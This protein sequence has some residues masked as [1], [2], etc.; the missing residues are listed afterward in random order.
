VATIIATALGVAIVAGTLVYTRSSQ[1]LRETP[2]LA[3]WSWDD[4]AYLSDAPDNLDV[5][6]LA[7]TAAKWP[8][9]ER[10]GAVT[11][12]MPAQLLLGEDNIEAG[13]LAFATDARMIRPA[14]MEGRA[15]ESPSEI[16]LSPLLARRLGASVGTSLPFSFGPAHG[17][18]DVVGLGP[19]PVLG[20]RFDRGAAITFG[21]QKSLLGDLAPTRPDFLLL[22]RRDG[23][24]PAALARRLR[25][26]GLAV[27]D[28]PIGDSVIDSVGIDTTRAES[29]PD[30]LALLMLAMTTAL[31][32]YVVTNAMHARRH[33]FAVLRALGF[34]RKATRA[35]TAIGASSVVAIVLLLGLPVGVVAGNAAW[36]A[37]ARELGVLNEP[38]VSPLE[39]VGL[40]AGGCI[41]A[42]VVAMAV[43]RGTLRRG[44]GDLLRTE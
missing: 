35:T 7:R 4:F 12:F 10:A 23:A 30:L 19:V 2:R 28:A 39:F 26:A 17:T 29:T 32:A 38:F 13:V 22:D 21:A 33:D 34:T 36:R 3:G 9:I 31:L 37:Y 24:D 42:L 18:L 5:A 16:L 43:A 15:P 44:V 6:D 14:A 11:V 25:A 41:T 40:A 20:A 8:E 27:D 1:H